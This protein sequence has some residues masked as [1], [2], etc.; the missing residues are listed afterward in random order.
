MDM[1]DRVLAV[2]MDNGWFEPADRDVMA[3]CMLL[4]TEVAEMAEAYRDDL[5]TEHV[6]YKVV[7]GDG[8]TQTVLVRLGS[9]E[10]L[11]YREDW[12]LVGKPQ[13]FPSECADVLVRLLDTCHR[14]GIDLSEA[15]DRKLAYNTT[16]GH[17]HGGK[18]A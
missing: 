17:R 14:Q 4:V 3:D 16:R 6:E 9:P 2:N 1:Q 18:L 10:D 7:H 12:G 13:G 11:N 15:F 5:M 8:A